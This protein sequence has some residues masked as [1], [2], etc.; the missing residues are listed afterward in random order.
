MSDVSRHTV[1]VVGGGAR[2]HALAW[3]FARSGHEVVV[4]PGNAGTARDA[5]FE[6]VAIPTNDH[7]ALIE[8]AANHAVDLTV[9]GPEE[10]LVD[11][12]VDAF[13]AAGLRV[14][15]P[16]RLGAQLEGSKAFTKAL[17]ARAGIPTAQA[18][19]ST[20]LA[21][22][23]AKLRT[24]GEPPVVKASGIA[25]GKGVI[26]AETFDEA[27]AALVAILADRRFG[28]AG[29]TVVLE[30]R[31]RGAEVSV[32]AICDGSHA[33]LLPLAQDHKRLLDGDEGPNTGGM[34]AFSPSPTVDTDLAER[35]RAEVIEPTLRTMA[36]D[37]ITYR[38]ILYAGIMLTADGPKLL[39][40]NCR[41]G[42]PETQAILPV[43]TEDLAALLLQSLEGPG[44]LR[45]H[46]NVR[47]HGA[48]C[49]VVI[50][51]QGYPTVAAVPR[52]IHGL[53]AAAAAGCVV[54]HAGT[55]LDLDGRV[56]ATG[57]RVLSVTGAA[58]TLA[59][60]VA[61]AY[62]GV[63]CISFDGAQHRTDIGRTFLA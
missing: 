59:D 10:P 60:A 6:T 9:I 16:N 53:D 38:G 43:L 41:L 22:A 29:D 31:L 47:A 44:A 56:L 4:A 17:C 34:G 30:E 26:V 1:L 40:F 58:D 21:D 11:G 20:D 24:F 18:E 23:R 62:R 3:S 63:A 25:A 61:Q 2:E 39:E 33:S 54:F 46:P 28:A 7:R 51:S 52:P 45:E 55:T 32:L 42:D 13:T 15:G 27:D 19:V 36:N 49:S 14:F 8:L 35:I 48:S 57:G 37:G 12:I 5:A 50:A